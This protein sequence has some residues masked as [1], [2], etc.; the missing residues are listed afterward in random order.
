MVL[1]KRKSDPFITRFYEITNRVQVEILV[2]HKLTFKDVLDMIIVMRNQKRPQGGFEF[3]YRLLT[4]LEG[5]FRFHS[6]L[7]Q[8]VC[9]YGGLLCR[10]V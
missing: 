4:I 2:N 5:H 10:R 8:C 7:V 6:S 3:L 1:I 9:L